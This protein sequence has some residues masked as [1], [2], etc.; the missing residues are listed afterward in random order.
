MEA[1][2]SQKEAQANALAKKKRNH[3]RAKAES[4]K[5]CSRLACAACSMES[6]RQLNILLA[7]LDQSTTAHSP[8]RGR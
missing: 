7:Q 5:R 4:K 3:K 1:L 2:D 8:R 6:E